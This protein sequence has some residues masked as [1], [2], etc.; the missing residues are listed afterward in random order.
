MNPLEELKEI[1]RV[2]GRLDKLLMLLFAAWGIA[3]A[4]WGVCLAVI[5]LAEIL[6]RW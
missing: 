2:L 3:A 5:L 4:S 6:K 1:E